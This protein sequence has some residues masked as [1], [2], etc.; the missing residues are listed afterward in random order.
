LRFTY[1][2]LG[3]IRDIQRTLAGRDRRSTSMRIADRLP[4][5]SRKSVSQFASLEYKNTSPIRRLA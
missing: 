4:A 1:H 3:E 5:A 2:V